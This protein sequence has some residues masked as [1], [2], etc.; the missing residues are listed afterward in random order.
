MKAFIGP[1]KDN[2]EKREIDIEI[3]NYDTWSMDETLS[4]I[5]LP[6]LKKLKEEKHGSPYV[7]LDDVPEHLRPTEVPE[8]G[9]DNKHHERWEWV[10]DEMIWAFEQNLTNWE[11]Q[12]YG[13]WVEDES[14]ILGGTHVGTDYDGMKAHGDRMANGFRLFGTY[15]QGLWD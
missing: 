11:D 12:Y 15:F 9:A 14:K 13:E 1:Y 2:G 6:M 7:E 5:I 8:Y 10:M 4:H 3:H